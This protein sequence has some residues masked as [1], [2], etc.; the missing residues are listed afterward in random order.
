M[1]L[2]RNFYALRLTAHNER[3]G[4][5]SFRINDAMSKA[6]IPIAW[7]GENA[8]T[9][10]TK[11]EDFCKRWFLVD[12]KV[13]NAFLEVPEAPPTRWERWSSEGFEGRKLGAVF[14]CLRVLRE[15]GVTCQMVVK[16]F[17]K[18]RIA[19]LQKH[20]ELMWKYSGPSDKMRLSADNFEE[21]VL[22]SIMGTLFTSAAIPQPR[23]SRAQPLFNFED[24]S[25]LEH[26]RT[27][28]R[29][30]EWGIVPD[31]HLGPR[32]NPRPVE[33]VETAE[34]AGSSA[35]SDS[36]EG[37]ASRGAGPSAGFASSSRSTLPVAGLQVVSSSSGEEE[38][39]D[40]KVGCCEL[41][42]K[43]S[44]DRAAEA[45]ESAPRGKARAPREGAEASSPQQLQTKKRVWG[46]A[47][48]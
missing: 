20:S 24:E 44:H 43:A 7:S 4:C 31:G 48:E 36:D 29:F 28:P 45:Q 40:N 23:T 16:D 27:L 6:Y 33:Q 12:A 38:E 13:K 26:V 15:A 34:S 30:D 22:N 46:S 25:V 18:H 3:T 2:F 42:A 9:C 32:E 17:M 5:V 37:D 11:V 10:V 47:D 35:S 8:I 41:R 21:P 39:S 1:D 19:P 14:E